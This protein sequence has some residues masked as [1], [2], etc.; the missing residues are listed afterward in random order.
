MKKIIYIASFLCAALLAG[1]DDF[2]TTE[3]PDF[4]TDKYWRDK[5][6]VEAGLSAVYGQLD[7]RTGSYTVAEV[8]FVVETFRSDEMVKGQD[9][10]NYP[11]WAALY[12]FTY[13]NENSSIKEYWMNNYNGINY[14]NNVLY[15]IDKVQIGRASC[16]ERV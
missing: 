7:N 6:D 15:G 16:R 5:A 2:L 4:S 10:N 11:E 9:V 12:G 8:K 3:S 14:A 1:C 13:N